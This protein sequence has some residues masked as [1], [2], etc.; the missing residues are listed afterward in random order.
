MIDNKFLIT[1]IGLVIAVFAI[2]NFKTA[3]A[4]NSRENFLGNLPSMKTKVLSQVNTPNGNYSL[5]MNSHLMGTSGPQKGDTYHTGG[6]FQSMLSPRFSNESYGA[7]IRYNTPS[8]D[9]MAVPN[10]PLGLSKMARENYSGCGKGGAKGYNPELDGQAGYT[11]GDYSDVASS[12]GYGNT[13]QQEAEYPDTMSMIPVGDMTTINAAGDVQSPVVYDRHVYA[14]RN[15]KLRGLGCH[16]RGDLPI[17]PCS[18]E[19]FR[20]SVQPHIDLQEGA[21]NVMGGFDNETN[22]ALSKLM[23]HSS[24]GADQ[25]LG[26]IDLNN[27]NMSNQF[28]TSIGPVSDISVSAY[29]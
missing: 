10:N 9:H 15:S 25:T 28:S 18:G 19:W 27:T 5:P 11:N 29:P 24:G 14:N 2:C 6:T 16:L 3:E 26:G 4:T 20:P 1:L 22:N 8:Y 12:A 21:L 7:N 13:G 17:A 23:F